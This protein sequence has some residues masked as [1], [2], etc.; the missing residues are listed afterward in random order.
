MH[1]I[2]CHAEFQCVNS[3]FLSFVWSEYIRNRYDSYFPCLTLE[4]VVRSMTLIPFSSSF[5]SNAT[6]NW[7]NPDFSFEFCCLFHSSSVSWNHCVC[8][9]VCKMR[10]TMPYHPM[11][12]WYAI[13]TP[14]SVQSKIL[15][16]TVHLMGK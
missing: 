14:N 11:P 8:V 6:M 9:C 15:L 13:R 10:I 1:V 3:L 4:L 5:F 16:F 2:F 12:W 7:L